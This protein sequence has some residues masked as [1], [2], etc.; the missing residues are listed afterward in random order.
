MFVQQPKKNVSSPLKK[1]DQPET[2]SSNLLEAKGT[3]M[4]QSMIG[5]LQ[6]MVTIGLLNITTAVMTMSGF[7][8]AHCNGKMNLWISIQNA[9]YSNLCPY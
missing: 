6:W 2:N 7:R 9:S 8:I 5:A 3:Q 1:G 4:Y